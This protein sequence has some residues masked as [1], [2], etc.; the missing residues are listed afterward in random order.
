M[1]RDI[2]PL[3]ARAEVCSTWV[4]R[5]LKCLNLGKYLALYAS[6]LIVNGTKALDRPFNLYVEQL[7]NRNT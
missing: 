2:K 6:P 7:T 4:A 5:D 3:T 1:L